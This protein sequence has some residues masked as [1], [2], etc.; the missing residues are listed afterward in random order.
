VPDN[1]PA[2]ANLGEKRFWIEWLPAWVRHGTLWDSLLGIRLEP[3]FKQSCLAGEVAAIGA[4]LNRSPA[5]SSGW[6]SSARLADV[7]EKVMD[8]D[9]VAGSA[10][11]IKGVVKQT[12]GKAVGAKLEPKASPTR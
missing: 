5:G 11:E 4:I 12:S 9:R 7:K 6:A 2:F 8:K 1:A 3:S 10:K